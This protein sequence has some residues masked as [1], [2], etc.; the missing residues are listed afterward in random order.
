[1]RGMLRSSCCSTSVLASLAT[2]WSIVEAILAH[3]APTAA[4][5]PQAIQSRAHPHLEQKHYGLDPYTSALL[6][7][8]YTST[9]TL[10]YNGHIGVR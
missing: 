2:N 4:T 6:P 7:P 5:G 8:E 9:S 10:Y 3:Q 1:M